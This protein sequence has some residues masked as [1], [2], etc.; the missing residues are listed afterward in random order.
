VQTTSGVNFD[1]FSKVCPICSPYKYGR[2]V[3]P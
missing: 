1:P 2:S 3:G